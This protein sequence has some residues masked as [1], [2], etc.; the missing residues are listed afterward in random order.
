MTPRLRSDSETSSDSWSIV[1]DGAHDIV[2]FSA[3]SDDSDIE[4]QNEQIVE[5]PISDN[6]NQESDVTQYSSEED[7]RYEDEEGE[8][9]EF[10]IQEY[11]EDRQNT[12]DDEDSDDEEEDEE[13]VEEDENCDDEEEEESESEDEIEDENE[14]PDNVLDEIPSLFV[15][16]SEL[17]I[18]PLVLFTSILIVFLPVLIT[19]Q[20]VLFRHPSPDVE[21]SQQRWVSAIAAEGSRRFLAWMRHQFQTNPYKHKEPDFPYKKLTEEMKR[22]ERE[23]NQIRRSKKWDF[24]YSGNYTSQMT[25]TT[26]FFKP[27]AEPVPPLNICEQKPRKNL[28]ITPQQKESDRRVLHQMRAFS[29]LVTPTIFKAHEVKTKAVQTLFRPKYRPQ[30]QYKTPIPCVVPTQKPSKYSQNDWYSE[31]NRV[32]ANLRKH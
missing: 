20:G 27:I 19:R 26:S 25:P 15:A 28:S 14:I 21:P 12:D 11:A 31:R 16:L 29:R 5:E 18:R 30:I 4:D 6:E 3:Q 22:K 9:E 2:E 7:D 24:L 17:K 13:K 1:E 32:R 23:M 8:Q 10:K